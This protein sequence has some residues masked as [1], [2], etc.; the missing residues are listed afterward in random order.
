MSRLIEEVTSDYH[1]E[2]TDNVGMHIT[3][4]YDRIDKITARKIVL[5]N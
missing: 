4:H 5:D 3:T 1:K 2:L